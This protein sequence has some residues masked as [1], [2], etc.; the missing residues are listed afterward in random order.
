MPQ[1]YIFV[2]DISGS[3]DKKK[4]DIVRTSIRK[5]F[6]SMSFIII[7]YLFAATK[8][9][10]EQT[11][12]AVWDDPEYQ[13]FVQDLKPS[14]LPLTAQEQKIPTKE[15]MARTWSQFEKIIRS[16]IVNF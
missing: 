4:L 2:I 6:N 3:M 8:T 10:A 7:L 11:L 14:V 13:A 15:I 12:Q 9:Y 5:L 16:R 1:N